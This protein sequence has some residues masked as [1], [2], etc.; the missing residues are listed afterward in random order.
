MCFP[1]EAMFAFKSTLTAYES[2]VV[3]VKS[4][5]NYKIIIFFLLNVLY[6]TV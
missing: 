1:G 4:Q 5:L 6:N 2:T 3:H